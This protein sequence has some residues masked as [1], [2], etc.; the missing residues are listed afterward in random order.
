MALSERQNEF[1][2]SE[3]QNRNCFLWKNPWIQGSVKTNFPIR[4][5]I[6][7]RDD[8]QIGIA[9][10]GGDPTQDGCFFEVDNVMSVLEEIRKNGMKKRNQKSV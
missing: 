5:A 3:C 8:V 4:S 9:E 2:G 7:S 6:L 1:A 10:N